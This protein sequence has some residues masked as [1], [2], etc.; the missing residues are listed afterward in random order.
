M[1]CSLLALKQLKNKGRRGATEYNLMAITLPLPTDQTDHMDNRFNQECRWWLTH[2][3]T[4]RCGSQPA[5][6]SGFIQVFQIQWQAYI[7]IFLLSAQLK[8]K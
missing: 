1:N 4:P 7:V 5:H 2:S 8:L 6:N 3:F